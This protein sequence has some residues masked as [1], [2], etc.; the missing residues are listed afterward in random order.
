MIGFDKL[1][2]TVV[3]KLKEFLTS[4]KFDREAWF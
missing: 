3:D 2:S 4:E 1:Q